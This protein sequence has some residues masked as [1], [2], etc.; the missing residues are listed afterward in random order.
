MQRKSPEQEEH[1]MKVFVAGGTGFVGSALIPDLLLHGHEVTALVRNPEKRRKLPAGIEVVEGSP[2][3]PG[4]WM[5]KLNAAEA[6]IN[7]TGA[8]IFTRWTAEAKKRILE[9]RTISTRNI[10]AAI[11]QGRAP[12][13]T[14]INAG[15]TG[16]YGFDGEEPKTEEA[17]PGSDFLARVCAAWEEEAFR[18]ADKG[19]RVAVARF[20]VVLGRQGGA[21]ATML[22]AFRLGLGGPLASGKQWFP[23]V[24]LADLTAALLF[25]IEQP[26]AGPVN[27]VA[28][29]PIR[30]QE[31]TAALAKA[32][33]RPALLRVPRLVLRTV[34][35]EMGSVLTEGA[36]VKP[37]VL[38]A[39]GFSFRFPTL[40]EAL[41][42]LVGPEAI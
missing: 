14:L 4:D 34:L 33:G 28:P 7:L 32:L 22:P 38:L 42:N 21:L 8:T 3:K 35:G 6:I 10:V 16:Y 39:A 11:A 26:I 19:V 20:G 18:A 25:L 1:G 40:D 13:V 30:N 31:F 27:V 36:A 5:A 23:W 12:G 9:S 24:H 17:P 37:Q 15:A 41:K 2:T 29:H